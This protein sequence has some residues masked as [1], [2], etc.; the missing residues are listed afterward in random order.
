VRLPLTDAILLY[1][2]TCKDAPTTKEI[3]RALERAGRESESQNPVRSVRHALKTLLATNDDLFHIGWARWHLKSKY[4]SAK[5]RKLLSGPQNGTGGHSPEEHSTR[6]RAGL[7]KAKA[8]GRRLGA[9]PKYTADHIAQLK[10]L[11]AAGSKVKHALDTV[12]VKPA[13]FYLYRPQIEAWKL[14]EPWP[15]IERHPLAGIGVE[16]PPSLFNAKGPPMR[17][18]RP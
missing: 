5:L 1:L 11:L 8:R 2:A 4:T 13:W 9:K 16:E 14:G 17:L 7:E 12:G 6:T 18:V 15:P 3:W 10:A